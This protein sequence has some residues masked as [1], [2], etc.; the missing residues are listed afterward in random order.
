MIP[1]LQEEIKDV[2]E[3]LKDPVKLL[4]DLVKQGKIDPW[5]VDV[6]EV[7]DKFLQELEN[8][9][10]LDL[11]VSGRVLLYAAILVR[12]KA[13]VLAEEVISNISDISECEEP[14]EC[15]VLDYDDY[16]EEFVE[17]TLSDLETI[18]NLENEPK[19][20]EI[21]AY[22]MQPHRKVRRFTTLKDLLT[23]LKKA[24]KVKRKRKPSR[25]KKVVLETPHEE[26]MEETICTV[27]K[28][29]ERLFDK[30][31]MVMFSEL[32]GDKNLSS[33]LSF[34]VSILYLSFRKKIE[35]EQK[36][37]YED[38]IVILPVSKDEKQ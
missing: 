8:A 16:C 34:F 28:I 18:R 11:R 37:I 26:D 10:K 1:E 7:A 13:E 22:L 36:R 19:E 29:L 25:V 30:K 24:E 3:R 12:M 32:V 6:V 20:D 2:G 21:I 23:E 5:N 35:I 33:K 27:E 17:D 4:V 15:L 14:Y 9:K 38:D 31:G